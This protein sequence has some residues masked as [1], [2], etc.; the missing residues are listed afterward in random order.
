MYNRERDGQSIAE[1]SAYDMNK[2]DNHTLRVE[3][4]PSGLEI[5]SLSNSRGPASVRHEV[6]V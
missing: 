1:T 3:K 2:V 5:L 4:V 6:L